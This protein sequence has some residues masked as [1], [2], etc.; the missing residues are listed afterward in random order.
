MSNI[1]QTVQDCFDVASLVNDT[2]NI[3][4]EPLELPSAWNDIAAETPVFIKTFNKPFA[5][6][7]V[8]HFFKDVCPIVFVCS[9]D[10]PYLSQFKKELPSDTQLLVFNKSAYFSSEITLDEFPYTP[11]YI[12]TSLFARRFINDYAVA[13]NLPFWMD[14]DNDLK[15]SLRFPDK[16][17]RP[18]SNEMARFAIAVHLYLLDKYPWLSY[19]SASSPG[20]QAYGKIYETG[21]GMNPTNIYFYN[22][23]V[24]WYGRIVDDVITPIKRVQTHG[25]IPLAL[26]IIS[27][28]QRLITGEMGITYRQ[29][30]NE[31][32][33]AGIINPNPKSAIGE[34]G[35]YYLQKAFP[36]EMNSFPK[37]F[38]RPYC[39]LLRRMLE[40]RFPDVLMR[41]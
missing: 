6:I 9:N 5:E 12:K 17:T 20:S 34:L 19:L 28:D 1:Y 4:Q 41:N 25:D 24:D 18:Y 29:L 32:E 22:K 35:R 26:P 8:Y 2:R 31:L 10:D 40:V 27:T 39:S 15:I 33:E 14:C 37:S 38:L 36:D 7:S 11:E 3:C 16:K 30:K 23:G 21:F 13:N